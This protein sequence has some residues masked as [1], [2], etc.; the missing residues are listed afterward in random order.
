MHISFLFRNCLEKR[1]NTS[2]AVERRRGRF[3][4][5]FGGVI[6]ELISDLA[7]HFQCLVQVLDA[8]GKRSPKTD[9]SVR[10]LQLSDTGVTDGISPKRT[11]APRSFRFATTPPTRK[12]DDLSYSVF[13][14]LV[15]K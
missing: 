8:N 11:I 1:K 12:T 7:V 15:S 5:K 2:N 9:H 3:R 13:P 14:T 4:S 6:E 10:K